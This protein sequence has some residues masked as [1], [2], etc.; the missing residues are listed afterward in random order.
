M[1]S[2][3]SYELGIKVDYSDTQELTDTPRMGQLEPLAW[4]GK[5]V[6]IG[7]IRLGCLSSLRP[8]AFNK[9][10]HAAVSLGEIVGES[11]ES[12]SE[13]VGVVRALQVLQ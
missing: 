3:R 13:V 2:F 11:R 4:P 9:F 1:K 6:A 7:K 8:G 12:I 5:R 10:R